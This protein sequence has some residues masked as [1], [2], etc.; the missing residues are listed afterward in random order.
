MNKNTELTLDAVRDALTFIP[1][2]D[3]DLWVKVGMA[4]KDEYADEARD[5]WF[6]WSVGAAN[7]NEQSATHV[8][9]SLNATGKVTIGSLIYE[10]KQ[11]GWK[12][13]RSDSRRITPEDYARKQAEREQRRSVD[14]NT[15]RVRAERAAK[16]ATEIWGQCQ[17]ATSHPYLERKDVQPHG[18]RVLPV[19]ERQS[20][21]KN[22]G[23]IITVSVLNSLVIPL[24]SGPKT[25]SSLQFIFAEPCA[26]LD[27]DRDFL[28]GGTK[29]G[30]YYIIGAITKSTLRIIFCE[31]FATGGSIHEATGAP[32]V[33]CFDAGNLGAV[34]MTI[35]AKLPDVEIII[36]GDNDLWTKGNPGARKANAAAHAVSG[37]VALP[38][39][40]NHDDH[41]TD[42][43]D[44]RFA[45]SIREQIE[46]AVEP[47]DPEHYVPDCQWRP[48]ATPQPEVGNNTGS[49]S[50]ADILPAGDGAVEVIPP[51]V[52][53]TAAGGEHEDDDDVQSESHFKVLGYD[54]DRYFVFQHERKQLA[55]YSA[56]SF[57]DAGF[58][59]LAP[60]N[61]WEIN[62]PAESGFNK[63]MALNWFVRTAHSR[64]IFDPS[65]TRGR[66]AWVDRGRVVLHMGNTLVVDGE[67]TAITEFKSRY[68]YEL[69]RSLPALAAAPLTAVEGAALLDIAKMFRWTKPA[70]APMLAGWCALAPLCGAMRWRPHVWLTGGA[71]TGKSWILNHFVHPLMNGMDIFA[72]GNSTEAGIR[73]TLRQDALPVLF[74]ESEK[75]NERER[76][77]VD[78]VLAL[79]RQASTESA[80][81]T[82]KGSAFGDA[83][84]FHIRS[85]FCLASIQVGMEHQA[86]YERLAVLALRPKR[87]EEAD[88][89]ERWK[90]I[91]DSVY[92]TVERDEDMPAR[93]FRRSLDLLPITLQNIDIFSTAG[94][95]KFGSQ[96][97]G[98]QYGTLM[99]GAW[100]LI[101][102]RVA[103]DEEARAMLDSYDWGEFME[104]ADTD[105]STKALSAIMGSHIRMPGGATLSVHELLLLS[106]YQDVAGASN[107]IKGA[108]AEAMLGRYGIKVADG[109]VIFANSC[110]SL[111]ELV[112]HTPFAADLKG[113]L[114]RTKGARRYPK[115]IWVNGITSR[116][117]SV[118]LSPLVGGLLSAKTDAEDDRPF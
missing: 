92:A 64:G 110:V 36:A 113:L 48:A 99:A 12:P 19:W 27:R 87:D 68:V 81:R 79:I 70:S 39:F 58:I 20:A 3:R 33:V 117:V 6:D 60:L 21:D 51:A 28:P 1:P 104:H 94:A 40:E 115:P 24:Y 13:K 18:A 57:T 105:D 62:F 69:D 78:G 41:P 108:P 30:C 54:H 35:R 43:N 91:Q 11:F 106:Q 84:H 55:V 44:L 9:K 74:D 5:L 52:A 98:D 38:I 61:F 45:E 67:T 63:R 83:Q 16:R 37:R 50:Q 32:V 107:D 111:H 72:Q 103:T 82:L 88:A 10:A 4:L 14:E 93:L 8:W 90:K 47:V 97:D 76:M 29:Q 86:D 59:A 65:H 26:A 101:S 89:A 22:T 100:S 75:N 31:G 80:A 95:T 53:P 15:N 46:S 49:T 73:Q 17:P 34:A 7:Y 71:G 114:L 77:R 102:D 25:I 2:D 56:G 112:S 42:F 96:R 23:E 85:M 116:G 109:E 118:P 66:G